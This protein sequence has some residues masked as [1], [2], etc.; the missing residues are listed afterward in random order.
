MSIWDTPTNK[1]VLDERQKADE[2]PFIGQEQ[3]KVQVEPYLD[4]ERFPHVLLTGD[5]G[6]GKTQFARWLAWRRQKPFFERLA[7]VR[8][9]GL[10][11]YGVL[12][13]DE[14]HRQRDVE[15]LFPKM[16]EGLL[17]VIAATTKPDRLDSAFKSRFL[18]TLRMRLYRNDEIEDIIYL[19]A[20]APNDCEPPILP[21]QGDND[22]ISVLA[23]AA[24][25]NPRVA[26]RIVRAAKGL[27]TWEPA[28]VLKAVQITADGISQDH[29]DYLKALNTLNRPVG[30]GQ[31]A[32]LALMSEDD[33]RRLERPLI[34]QGY[35]ELSPSGRKLTVRGKQYVSLLEDEGVL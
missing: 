10:P 4:E 31:I 28:E 30:R 35:V 14:V 24:Q 32:D 17:T 9:E 16:E 12:F 13:L 34:E 6:L 20:G 15:S 18:L 27:D 11:P 3:I 2:V 26:E 19:M 5:P 8:S 21:D 7:P 29:F 25:G 22:H 23:N 33:V 1:T